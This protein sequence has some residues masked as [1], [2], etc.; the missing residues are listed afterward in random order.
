MNINNSKFY[1]LND[2][3]IFAQKLLGEW[4]YFDKNGWH[5]LTE[6]I[7]IQ[8]K[9]CEQDTAKFYQNTGER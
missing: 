2:E 4:H 5:P 6:M 1:L 3:R 7:A 8:L 9:D